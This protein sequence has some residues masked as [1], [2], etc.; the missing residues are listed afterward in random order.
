MGYREVVKV[1]KKNGWFEVRSN[2]SS[3]HQFKHKDRPGKVTVAEH[4]NKDIPIKTLESIEK[5]S[6]LSLRR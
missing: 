1:L 4:G 5:Q 3:H 2:G 6:G